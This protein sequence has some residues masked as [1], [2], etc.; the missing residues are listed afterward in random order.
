MNPLD[1]KALGGLNKTQTKTMEQQSLLNAISTLVGSIDP[2][3]RAEQKEAVAIV[4]AKL[5]E[6]VAHVK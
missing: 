2:L 1:E 3:V 4:T 6:L 5:L